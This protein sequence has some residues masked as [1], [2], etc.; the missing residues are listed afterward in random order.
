[1]ETTRA[2]RLRRDV[3]IVAG[4]DARDHLQSQ[5]TQDVVALDIGDHAWSFLLDPKAS[6]IAL[7]RITRSGEST[8][9]LDTEEGWGDAVRNAIEGFLFRMD[10][11]FASDC[12]DHVAVRGPGAASVTV[13]APIEA[14]VRWGALEGVDL[15]GPELPEVD[16]IA[17]ASPEAYDSLRIWAGWPAMGKEIVEKTTP[18]MTGL[19]DDT[20]SFTKGCYPGQ[21]FVARV[22]YRDAA[23]PRRIVQVQFHPCAE[24]TAG[25]ELTLDGEQVGVITSVADCQPFALASLVRSVDVPVDLAVCGCPA[26]A[27]AVPDRMATG[28]SSRPSPVI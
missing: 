11:S 23:P 24:V 2:A 26:T 17:E 1:M 4:A 12:W 14:P 18:A 7:L 25:A 19:V 27:H 6:I 3:V 15:I 16:G 13:G 28:T 22:H 8:Y 10:V 9:L 5:L 21:E 20:V